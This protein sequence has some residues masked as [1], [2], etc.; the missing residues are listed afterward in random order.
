MCTSISDILLDT[1][2]VKCFR[3]YQLLTLCFRRLI[4]QVNVRFSFS[5][6]DLNNTNLLIHVYCVLRNTLHWD[7]MA[8][9]SCGRRPS[10]PRP[11]CRWPYHLGLNCRVG[12]FRLMTSPGV[13]LPTQSQMAN[14]NIFKFDILKFMIS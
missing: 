2:I 3:Y 9:G 11:K 13:K 1:R 7:K 10:R 5:S 6:V 8:D 12:H 4:K 14:E